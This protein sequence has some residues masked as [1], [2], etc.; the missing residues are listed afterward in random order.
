M[1]DKDDKQEEKQEEN[2]QQEAANVADLSV[3]TIIAALHENAVAKSNAASKG[4]KVTN[5]AIDSESGKPQLNSAGEHIISVLPLEAETPVQKKDAVEILQQYVQWFVGPDLAKKVNDSTVKSLDE[6][7]DQKKELSESKKFMS[8]KRFL[9]EAEEESSEES[10]D[11]GSDKTTEP[12]DGTEGEDSSSSDG[13]EKKDDD[14]NKDSEAKDDEKKDDGSSSIGYYIPYGMKVEGLKQT[15]LKDAMKKFASTMFDDLK[16]K[17]DG[18]FGGGQEFTVKDAK[19]ALRGVFGPID[20]DDLVDKVE[21][22]VNSIRHPNTD[23]AQI[24]VRDKTTL[25]ADLGKA[26]NAQQKAQINKA[27]YSLWIKLQEYDPKKPIF[28]TRVVA[29]I[30]QSSITG[31]FKKFKNKITKNDVIYIENYKDQHDDTESLEQLNKDVPEV[32]EFTGYMRSERASISKVWSQI[33]K[34]LDKIGKNKQFKYSDLAQQCLDVWDRFKKK[35]NDDDERTSTQ[36]AGSAAI[37]KYFK[38]F[39]SEYKKAFDKNK[40]QHNLHESIKLD[41]DALR[42]VGLL[43]EFR[44]FVFE[45][46]Y[47]EAEETKDKD[48]SIDSAAIEQTAK[49]VFSHELSKFAHTIKVGSKDTLK[50]ALSKYDLSGFDTKFGEFTNGIAVDFGKLMQESV[51]QSIMSILFEADDSSSNFPTLEEVQKAFKL[52][53]KK[54]GIDNYG[55]VIPLYFDNDAEEKQTEP[56]EKN[57]SAE[58]ETS[59]E[60]E[61]K[62]D[63]K[64]SLNEA[65]DE[66][67]IDDDDLKNITSAF[68]NK[69]VDIGKEASKLSIKPLAKVGSSSTVQE[70]LDKYG[71]ATGD[72]KKKLEEFPY[73]AVHVLKI[74]VDLD[75]SGKLKKGSLGF[76]A[77]TDENVKSALESTV[78]ISIEEPVLSFEQKANS[79]LLYHGTKVP[80]NCKV[81]MMFFNQPETA[82]G[83][84][85][86]TPTPPD[87]APPKPGKTGEKPAEAYV[88]PIGGDPIEPP[89]PTPDDD[90]GG[91]S[92]L[93]DGSNTKY[94]DLYIIPMPGLKYKDKEYNTYA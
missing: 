20:P 68:R 85:P 81:R 73:A 65:E 33:D 63:D 28:N 15:A 78:G 94:E 53:C 62:S 90:T 61:E 16:I 4:L 26:I 87:P 44:K 45:S 58:E 25:I 82:A 51:K 50:T 39:I 35:H 10:S 14:K 19:E 88:L 37:E 40:S 1:A 13:E 93:G 86:D 2:L 5:S 71:L 75:G 57:N 56:E 18:L 59:G 42:H 64:E 27:D 55:D 80:A 9:L 92:G 89:A 76:K 29:D 72:V 31:L 21:K 69:L 66:D 91:D 60:P 6:S 17:A 79:N 54:A 22:E 70:W 84:D 23:T 12:A 32:S 3:P 38:D 11:S 43:S 67:S 52:V 8:F 36:A 74:P 41:L 77:Y 47:G 30:V 49:D 83:E 7:P 34:S 48:A 46:L 24:R